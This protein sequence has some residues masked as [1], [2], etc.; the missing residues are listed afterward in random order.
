MSKKLYIVLIVVMALLLAS[1]ASVGA[2]S[3]EQAAEPTAAPQQEEPAAEEPAE[4]PAVEEPAE[5]TAE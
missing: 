3:G 4:E 1:C 5:T 2:P